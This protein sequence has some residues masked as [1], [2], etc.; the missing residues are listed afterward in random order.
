M[1]GAGRGRGRRKRRRVGRVPF[2]PIGR[3]RGSTMRMLTD[4]GYEIPDWRLAGSALAYA[5]LRLHYSHLV[6]SESGS[7]AE[8]L[9]R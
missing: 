5:A 2:A 4:A 6:L 1:A 7:N 8:S 3:D 9:A